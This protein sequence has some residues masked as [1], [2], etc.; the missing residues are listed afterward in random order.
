M[1]QQG[2]LR[3][4]RN[5]RRCLCVW[6][7]E[8]THIRLVPGRWQR[9]RW[10]QAAY[11]RGGCGSSL[12]C[13]DYRCLFYRRGY[14]SLLGRGLLEL[15][16]Q[17]ARRR[18]LPQLRALAL[19]A[20]QRQLIPVVQRLLLEVAVQRLLLEVRLGLL[21]LGPTLRLLALRQVAG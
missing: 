15:S 8:E 21:A 5:C 13:R 11:Y 18:S 1:R 10:R 3:W 12:S 19:A 4:R 6:T 9:E 2:R 20:V 7:W 17:K 14:R 16:L